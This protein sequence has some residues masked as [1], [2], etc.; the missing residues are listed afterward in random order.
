MCGASGLSDPAK[1]IVDNGAHH[2]ITSRL[3]VGLSNRG[4]RYDGNT[5]VIGVFVPPNLPDS[6]DRC[7]R[8]RGD[9]EP[10]DMMLS[11]GSYQKV[12]RVANHG[13]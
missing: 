13:A 1:K 9:V 7:A 6:D 11:L 2:L 3:L 4:L 8:Q 5:V 12:H 10:Q